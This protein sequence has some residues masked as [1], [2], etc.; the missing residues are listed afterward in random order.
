MELAHGYSNIQQRIFDAFPPYPETVTLFTLRRLLPCF[1]ALTVK[2]SVYQLVKRQCVEKAAGMAVYRLTKGARRPV[3][4][5]GQHGNSGRR[6]LA[7]K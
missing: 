6:P 5:R 4:L 1:T 2:K 7:G 3:D